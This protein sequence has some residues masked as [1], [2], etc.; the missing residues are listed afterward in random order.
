MKRHLL[1]AA[2]LLCLAATSCADQTAT[3]ADGSTSVMT[4]AQQVAAFDAKAQSDIKAF[5]ANAM[6]NTIAVGKSACGYLSEAHGLFVVAGPTM[7]IAGVD[8]AVGA[9][10]AAVMLAVQLNCKLIDAADPA[11][12]AVPQ[13]LN[14]VV[15]VVA[16]IP[17]IKN[18]LA[19]TAP[20][21]AAAATAP[22]A[23]H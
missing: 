18:A 2:G 16:A 9:T 14:A 15:Q 7:A 21:V 8:P 1:T 4:F 6:T 5:N 23:D 11:Q 12:P 19:E 3:N 20:T 22:A 10:E 13:V 17:Q